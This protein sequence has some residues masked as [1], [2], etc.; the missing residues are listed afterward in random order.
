MEAKNISSKDTLE[1]RKQDGIE[2][3][4]QEPVVEKLIN[5]FRGEITDF[6]KH[7]RH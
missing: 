2:N 6:K 7:E 5:T 1:S 3:L 4:M